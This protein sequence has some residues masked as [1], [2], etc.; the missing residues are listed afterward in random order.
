MAGAPSTAKY[1]GGAGTSEDPFLI[2]DANDLVEMRSYPEDWDKHFALTADIDM[3]GRSY[4]RAVIA[5]DSTGGDHV[6]DG[7]PFAGVFDGRA[8][9]ILNLT[10][11]TEGAQRD[12]LGLMGQI[13]QGAI[14]KNVRLVNCTVLYGRDAACVSG[15]VGCNDGGTVQNCRVSGA[16]AYYG[17]GY[18]GWVEHVGLVVGRNKGGDVADCE[19]AGEIGEAYQN[20]GGLIGRLDE[21]AVLRCCGQVEVSGLYVGGLVGNNLSGTIADCVST[22][23]VAGGTAGG[24]VGL[25]GGVVTDCRSQGNV[26]GGLSG[27]DVGGL[28]GVNSSTGLIRRSRA[29][30]A[31]ASDKFS[32]RTGGLVGSNG[33]SVEDCSVSGAVGAANTRGVGGLAGQNGGAITGCRAE[34]DITV[35]EICQS[36]GGL[37]GSNTGSVVNCYARGSIVGLGYHNFVGGLVGSLYRGELGY[38]YA[39]VALSC[40]EATWTDPVAGYIDEASYEECFWNIDVVTWGGAGKALTTADMKM[41]YPFMKWGCSGAWVIDEGDDY[42][43]L[44]WEGMPGEQI[45]CVV[46]E[47]KGTEEEPWLI[48]SQLEFDA[49]AA[50]SDY[51]GGCV[52]LECDIDLAGRTYLYAVVAPY[53]S[54][55]YQ[56]G[57]FLD[58]SFAGTFDGD[59]HCVRNLFI[60]GGN[61]SAGYKGLFGSIAETG[62]VKNLQVL[63]CL[64]HLGDLTSP[65]WP[66]GMC[67]GALAGL[68]AGAVSRCYSSGVV[69]M[70]DYWWD[71]GGLVGTNRSMAAGEPAGTTEMCASDCSI[72]GGANVRLVGG[73]IG[74]NA[75][76]TIVNCF[77][78]GAVS[79]GENSSEV[80]SLTGYN[81]GVIRWSYAAGSIQAG[82]GSTMVGGLVGRAGNEANV[83]ASFWDREV[84]GQAVSGG[85]VGL[86][87]YELRREEVYLQAGWDFVGEVANGVQDL[88]TICEATNY[89]RLVW[90]VPRADIACP[91]GV[92]LEDYAMLVAAWLSGPG[93]GRWNAACDLSAAKPPLIDVADLVVL[94][95]QW[96]ES[97]SMRPLLLPA[98]YWRF[99]D[100]S[101]NKAADAGPLGRVGTLLNMGEGA[102]VE[103]KAGGG[104]MFDGVSDYVTIAGWKGIGGGL[105]RTCCAWIKTVDMDGAVVSWGP[106]G[107]SGGRWVLATEGAGRLRLEVGGGA[108]VGSTLICDG[109]WHHVAAVLEYDGTPN[110]NEVRLYVDGLLD[111]ASSASDR[112]ISTVI[113]TASPDVAIGAWPPGGRYFAAVIDEVRI[114]DR[115][116][117]PDE[118]AALA[119]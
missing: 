88:W 43:R 37:V 92:A 41:M 16:I 52:R 72:R 31:V 77:S 25:N 33:G 6:F 114:Y 23:A 95:E 61:V 15:L 87:T 115:A 1:G 118:L 116:L 3:A 57:G 78:R 91:E 48:R 26:G 5:R 108:I 8:F 2:G 82:A 81:G 22:G 80:A 49:F 38:C 19:A 66:H 107:V 105:A 62:S 28:V 59:G 4:G 113:D 102:W 9:G 56:S 53:V 119:R 73:L 29:T 112:V 104:L 27:S 54:T 117:S 17:P 96:L 70:G 110:V 20:I 76:G 84:S 94:S 45:P 90:Q 39:A 7:T 51:W 89:P 65:Q 44:A 106:T 109:Q 32:N 46:L 64:I 86:D 68:N 10:I 24:L 99:E 35:E 58:G 111:T 12:Y 42:P 75:G 47:G 11:S 13:G 101:G 97:W 60:D 14:V 85:G 67:A 100:A 103:G 36:V 93:D 18:A 71:V 69:E 21:G 34:A 50:D 79:S 30:G 63:D 74:S 40:P 98:A 83:E 55:G